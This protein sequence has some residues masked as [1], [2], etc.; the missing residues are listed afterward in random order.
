MPTSINGNR[1]SS[2][3][4]LRDYNSSIIALSQDPNPKY[5][6]DS[7]T[8]R[9]PNYIYNRPCRYLFLYIIM[10]L[11]HIIYIIGKGQQCITT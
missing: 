10:Q 2:T 3:I 8:Q 9:A 11:H 1:E 5:T 6:I 7:H 4:K